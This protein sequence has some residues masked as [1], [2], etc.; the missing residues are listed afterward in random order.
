M[1]IDSYDLA[2]LMVE[3]ANERFGTK[4]FPRRQ[5]M[6]ATEQEVKRRGLWTSEDEPLSGSTDPKSRGLAYIDFR[7]TDL[8]RR[9]TIVKVRHGV[10]QLA[11][12]K[13]LP[14]KEFVSA[15]SDL[16]ELPPRFESRV[17]RV[18]RDTRTAQELK[19][20]YEFRCQVCGF[21]LEPSP[22]TFYIEVHHVRPL[23]G[24]HDGL[25][26]SNNMLVL[27][28]NHHAMFDFG[29]PRFLSPNDIEMAGTRYPLTTKH[30]LAP[31]VITYHNNVIHKPTDR[32]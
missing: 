22:G 32:P 26:T 2:N 31:D 12:P 13:L 7:F 15:P 28:P 21:R 16:A 24:G 19:S 25:D 5:L 10:W 1:K 29:I 6:E 3:I 11:A 17:S 20:L 9:G 4:A 23:G 14:V 18:I 30:H 27:C 8:S